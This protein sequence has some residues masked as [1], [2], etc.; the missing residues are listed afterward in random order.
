[1]QISELH[2]L[3]VA[4]MLRMTEYLIKAAQDLELGRAERLY[5]DAFDAIALGSS[6]NDGLEALASA[7]ASSTVS[8]G[9]GRQ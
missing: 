7:A 2:K 3:D 5:R 1:M 8:E 9:I 4:A 6:S